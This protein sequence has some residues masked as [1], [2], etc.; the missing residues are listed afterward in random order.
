VNDVM[1][2]YSKKV[3]YQVGYAPPSTSTAA[4]TTG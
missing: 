4:T 3:D 2:E 1:K